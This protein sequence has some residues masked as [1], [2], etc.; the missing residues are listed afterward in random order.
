MLTHFFGWEKSNF[1]SIFSGP[2]KTYNGSRTT[3]PTQ[4]GIRF[5][6]IK[7]IVVQVS[8]S[9]CFLLALPVLSKGLSYS[10]NREQSWYKTRSIFHMVLWKC[11][12]EEAIYIQQPPKCYFCEWNLI[13]VQWQEEKYHLAK[14][15]DNIFVFV[16]L[17]ELKERKSQSTH[18]IYSH[19]CQQNTCHNLTS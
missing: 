19:C 10:L 11:I 17:T 7:V 12:Q 9:L 2:L 5:R 14:W 13:I 18:L 16:G 4:T 15:A 1:N 3:R 8:F 6:L